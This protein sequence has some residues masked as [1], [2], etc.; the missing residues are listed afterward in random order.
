D[1][2]GIEDLE[3]AEARPRTERSGGGEVG[4]EERDLSLPRVR[5]DSVTVPAQERR[6]A[7][8][9]GSGERARQLLG[10]GQR[11]ELIEP[12]L[13]ARPQRGGEVAGVE[14]GGRVR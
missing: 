11:G 3:G 13:G 2:V 1:D 14:R 8:H 7:R 5:V 12:E 4:Q 10:G 6:R 9:V